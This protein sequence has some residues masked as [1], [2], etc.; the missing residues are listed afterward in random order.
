MRTGTWRR[1]IRLPYVRR[2]AGRTTARCGTRDRRGEPGSDLNANSIPAQH[3]LND[4][5]RPDHEE[6]RRVEKDAAK[7]QPHEEPNGRDD[8]RQDAADCAGV[9]AAEPSPLEYDAR[10]AFPLLACLG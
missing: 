3:P 9:D 2:A 8:H 4:G 5:E 1:S 10:L 7:R 6:D